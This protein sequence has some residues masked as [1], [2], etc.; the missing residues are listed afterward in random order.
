MTRHIEIDDRELRKKIKEHLFVLAGN[1]KLKIYGRLNCKS[2][3]RMKKENRVFFTSEEEAIEQGFRPCGNCLRKQYELNLSESGF[4]GFKDEQD[5]IF[6]PDN[7]KILSESGFAGFQDEQD[8]IF[9]PDN[10]KIL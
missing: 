7:P 8:V 1:S 4:T 10:P 5:V 6:H 2:G 3:K 9:H